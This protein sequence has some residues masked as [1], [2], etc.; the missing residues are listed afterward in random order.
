M[1][2]AKAMLYAGFFLLGLG[3]CTMSSANP[4]VTPGDGYVAITAEQVG[5]QAKTLTTSVQTY[6]RDGYKIESVR[7]YTVVGDLPWVAVSKNAQ[8]RFVEDNISVTRPPWHRV[9]YDLVDLFE[10]KDGNAVAVSM[11]QQPLANGRKLVGYF[12]LSR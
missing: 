8:N 4:S 1:T 9:G 3:G 2:Y 11:I 5:E 10:T 12:T 6:L 7:Y